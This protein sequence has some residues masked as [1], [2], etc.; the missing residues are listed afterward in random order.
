MKMVLIQCDFWEIVSGTEVYPE[1]V[2]GADGAETA[3]S[4][5]ARAN[6]KRKDS[7]ALAEI[8]LHLCHSQLHLVKKTET[9]SDAWQALCGYYEQKS[10]VSVIFL[11]RQYQAAKMKESEDM[12]AHISKHQEI[13]DQLA[14]VGVPVDES[15]QAYTL[16][17]SLPDSYESFSD[18]LALTLGGQQ[19]AL[20]TVK[21]T[22]IL[23]ERKRKEKASPGQSSDAL[24]VSK[25]HKPYQ[26][27]AGGFRGNRGAVQP[28]N[29]ATA[30][31]FRSR[32]F[33]GRANASNLGRKCFNCGKPG[34]IASECGVN[35]SAGKCYNCGRPGH[36]AANCWSNG[37]SSGNEQKAN[38]ADAGRA[39]LFFTRTLLTSQALKAQSQK[40][41]VDSGATQHMCNDKS[42]MQGFYELAGAE[43]IHLANNAT[44]PGTG[45][46][47]VSWY[48]DKLQSKC[49]F[50]N[51]LHAP[52]LN[53]NLLSVRRIVKGGFHVLFDEEGCKVIDPTTDEIVAVAKDID[54]LYELQGCSNLKG[55]TASVAMTEG[56]LELWHRRMGHIHPEGLLQ[57][58]RQKMV[59]GLPLKKD[60]KLKFCGSC[61]Y[62]KQSRSPFPKGAVRAKEV[63]EIIHSDLCG[64]NSTS[65]GGSKY[66]ITFIDDYSR[67]VAVYFMREKSQALS[68]FKTYVAAME[69]LTGKKVKILQTDNGTEY[70]NKEFNEYLNG[71]GIQ[72]R[73]TVPYTPE[74]N[75]VA[76]RFNRTLG[77]SARSML[78]YA[79]LPN[80]FWAE[81]VCTA[82]FVRNRSV[83]KAVN[84]QVPF[85]AMF[86]RKPDVS[87]FR[88]FGCDAYAHVVK[89]KRSKFDAKSEKC[90]FMGYSL[91]SKGY[92][93][94]NPRTR[95]A[96]IHRDVK[97]DESSF[98]G[99][100]EHSDVVREAEVVE[101]QFDGDSE[102]ILVEQETD[103]NEEQAD[104]GSD[105]GGGDQ[106]EQEDSADQ[107]EQPEALRRSKRVPTKP[108]NLPGVITGNWYQGLHIPGPKPPKAN[109]VFT[110]VEDSLSLSLGEPD[111]YSEAV[112][113]ADSQKWKEAMKSEYDSLIRNETWKLVSLPKDRKAIGNKWVY[114]IKR[115]ADGSVERYKARLVCKGFSQKEGIDYTETFSPVARYTSVRTVLAVTNQLG[116]HIHQ[117]DVKTAFLNGKLEEELYMVQPEGFVEEGKEHLV[118]KLE[119]SLYGLKQASRCWN[120]TIDQF[121]KKAGFQQGNAD[122]CVYFKSVGQ[123]FVIIALYVDDLLIASTSEHLL[124]EEKKALAT[125][126]EMS[127]MGEAHYILG[128]QITRH[129]KNRKL[130]LS[131]RKYLEN[132]LVKF[133]MQDS[134]PVCTPQETGLVLE[135]NMGEPVDIQKYQSAIGSLN[136]AV[137]A[138]RPDLAAALS[139]VNI[140]MQ[141]PGKTHWAA[142]KRILRY[143]KGTLDFGIM[144]DASSQGNE[145]VLHGYAD[146]DWAGS[147]N[148][149]S[150]SGSVFFVG[151]GPI[152]WGSKRQAVVALSTTEAEY[153]A[154][155]GA[156]QE[157]VW[158]RELLAGMNFVQSEPTCLRQDNMGAICLSKNP[159]F[160]GRSKHIDVKVHYIREL[161][162]GQQIVLSYCPTSEMIADF[163]TK[164]LARD[165]FQNLRY[166][167]SI[168]PDD[169]T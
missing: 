23:E 46:G 127:D 91:E 35:Q 159:S 19:L 71:K 17:L 37:Q 41:Y 34:H 109:V 62:G 169:V 153:I 148:R 29:R 48:N 152:S 126:F 165:K 21:Q 167:A 31:G 47:Q 40:W 102:P 117:M 57:M 36:I 150:T 44:V 70:V 155:S 65:I 32:G 25:G 128:M 43:P 133:G 120:V 68:F 115:N 124:R 149:R 4:V 88:I 81:A 166:A 122:P 142:V 3:V 164:P 161:V 74:Q 156:G 97:F 22:L 12:M 39:S 104:S 113:S 79:G 51:V 80:Q 139:A 86:G 103:R 90:W 110:G 94:Y 11:K 50:S 151:G 168:M 111:T 132:V 5:T 27:S 13:A 33:R 38:V 49:I 163:L 106:S 96:H 76:E 53:Q 14:G 145:V 121:L 116:L 63:M 75:G 130:F 7:K 114:K 85:E 160:H 143:I 56:D 24:F 136:Y 99:R 54:E 144:F 123:H 64:P 107:E 154:A 93:L 105:Q 95:Q 135:P 72:R 134:N 82:A 6:W 59:N 129:R 55:Q 20:E 67:H 146:A 58:S 9:S 138:T 73:L 15:E 141:N 1:P 52:E 147:S 101:S 89:Q 45:I 98:S 157:I 158:L 78:Q 2:N 30:R 118:C 162:S 92:R 28:G 108:T 42:V 100:I 131:Q 125:R 10:H 66:F 69:N 87:H 137:Q 60:S 16:L 26:S 84:G 112:E 119:R 61:Q 140:Y 8:S 83:T 18:T 77:E